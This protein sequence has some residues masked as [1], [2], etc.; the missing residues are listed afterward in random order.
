MHC[1]RY[2]L[3]VG[4][5]SNCSYVNR[6]TLENQWSSFLEKDPISKKLQHE[7]AASHLLL[8]R[9]C[10]TFKNHVRKCLLSK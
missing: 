9:S 10:M 2:S 8:V 7:T 5:I 6:D 1:C 4:E 3:I